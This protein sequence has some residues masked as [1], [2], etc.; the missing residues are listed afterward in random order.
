MVMGDLAASGTLQALGVGAQ[1]RLAMPRLM[2]HFLEL[3]CMW[4]LRSHSGMAFSGLRCKTIS[5]SSS[6][7][8]LAA[9]RVRRGQWFVVSLFYFAEVC[10][11]GVL[12]FC[13]KH[14]H[15]GLLWDFVIITGVTGFVGTYSD[16]LN[17]MWLG[18]A[19]NLAKRIFAFCRKMSM[20]VFVRRF[21]SFSSACYWIEVAFACT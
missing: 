14:S 15:A 12:I 4:M 5:R 17:G 6:T 18:S 9:M 11:I 10:Y 16:Y 3:D 19:K 8:P 20:G 2:L 1:L 13:I 7:D 21:G